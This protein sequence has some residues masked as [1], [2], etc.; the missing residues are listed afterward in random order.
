MTHDGLIV[1]A[2]S[3]GSGK[4]TVTLGLLRAFA[5]HGVNVCPAKVG[6]DYI[7]PRFHEAACGRPSV[8][9][10]GWAMRPAL[11]AELANDVASTSD[12]AVVEGVMGLFDGAQQ[13]GTLGNGTT[14]DIARFTGWPVIL[15]V[16]CSGLAQSVA[17]LVEGFRRFDPGV[18]IAGAILNKAGGPRHWDTLRQA[19]EPIGLPVVGV[20]PRDAKVEL[21][22]RHLG[23][24]QAE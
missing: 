8:N 13:P 5:R 14:A 12:L 15:V 16:D 18:T 10:D 9:L 20:L 19:L 11:V 2:P 6:P 7:D 22:S 17:P 1:A 4:T 23:L 21:P 24:V 3:T